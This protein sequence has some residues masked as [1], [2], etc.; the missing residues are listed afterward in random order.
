MADRDYFIRSRPPS[1]VHETEV[2]SVADLTRRIKLVLK[3]GVPPSWVRGEVSN[4]RTQASGHVYFSLKERESAIGCVMFRG[5]AVRSGSA[6]VLRDGA[7]VVVYGEIDVYEPRGNYQLIV[8]VAV[9]DGL[10]R[11]Q[12]AFEQLKQKLAAEGLFDAARKKKLP[13]LPATIGFIT[14]RTGAAIHDF[15]R[16]LQRRRWRG[17]LIVLP[18]RVQGD[19]AAAEMIDALGCAQQLSASG[20]GPRFELL[21]IGRGGGSIEDLWAFNEEPLVRAVAACTIPII[22]AVGHEIDFTLCDFAADARAETPSAAAELISSSYLDVVERLRQAEERLDVAADRWLRSQR[23]ALDLMRSR[24][25]FV[26]PAARLEHAYLRL[27]DLSNRLSAATRHA[28]QLH[29]HQ[30]G[31]LAERLARSGPAVMLARARERVHAVEV[32]LLRE[33]HVW[34]DQRRKKLARLEERLCAAGPESVLRRGYVIM[35]D[36]ERRVITSRAAVTPGQKLTAQWHDGEAPV[37]VE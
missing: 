25:S 14:S 29:R 4:L 31:E 13:L 19:G 23:G 16:I 2:E 1:L 3:T 22:S 20:T 32:R 33:I 12:Q 35:R 7:Q 21:V 28:L 15:V 26:T 10:G 8:R 6:P 34:R 11:L 18:V 9:D 27:D 36:A 30:L 24:M 17:R 5:D 37:K